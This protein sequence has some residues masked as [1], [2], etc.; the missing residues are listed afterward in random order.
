MT[1]DDALAYLQGKAAE[2]NGR[3]T[4]YDYPAWASA[5][6]DMA[7]SFLEHQDD[8]EIQNAL[9]EMADRLR[10]RKRAI[11]GNQKRPDPDGELAILREAMEAPV[12]H[13]WLWPEKL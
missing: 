6:E 12:T 4:P 13:F 3:W 11:L 5:V 10:A 1:R 9:I 7:D 2:A 8:E